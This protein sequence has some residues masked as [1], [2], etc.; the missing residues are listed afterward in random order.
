MSHPL[1][2]SYLGKYKII[3]VAETN[4]SSISFRAFDTETNIKKLVIVFKESYAS[5][6]KQ[7]QT[8]YKH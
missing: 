2:G 4:N 8:L 1:I 7:K 6:E 3:S 5:T